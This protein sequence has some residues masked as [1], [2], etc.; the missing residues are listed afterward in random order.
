MSDTLPIQDLLPTC[1]YWLQ[2]QINPL[3]P[4]INARIT[5]M[6]TSETPVLFASSVVIGE[7][8]NAPAPTICVWSESGSQPQQLQMNGYTPQ[9]KIAEMFKIRVVLPEVSDSNTT[10]DFELSKQIATSELRAFFLDTT[11][12]MQPGIY[13]KANPAVII[14]A[15]PPCVPGN[16]RS[17]F[18]KPMSDKTTLPRSVEMT[19][20]F[21]FLIAGDA[22]LSA[23]PIPAS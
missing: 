6:Y 3:I 10:S 16:W 5:A 13:T 9:S 4:V 8:P 18:A 2:Q 11:K 20:T 22:V 23:T 12:T 15:F 21:R 14:N 19:F 1:T 17:V 7:L